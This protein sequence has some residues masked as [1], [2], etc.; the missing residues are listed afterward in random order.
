MEAKLLEVLLIE[1]R[2][3]RSVVLAYPGGPA[4][5]IPPTT[6]D[7]AAAIS[8]FCIQLA[9]TSQV[10]V[11]EIAT[12]PLLAEVEGPVLHTLAVNSGTPELRDGD[13]RPHD[14][15]ADDAFDEWVEALLRVLQ[16]WV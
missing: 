12:A 10:H 16:L 13:G 5:S 8:D 4:G 6:L 1:Q 14:W 7:G 11:L 3:R 15:I 9:R 2:A